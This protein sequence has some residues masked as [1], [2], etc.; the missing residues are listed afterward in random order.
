MGHAE[1]HEA[2]HPTFQAGS[3][4]AR[5]QFNSLT[6]AGKKFCHYVPLAP[7]DGYYRTVMVVEGE[8]GYFDLG[9]STKDLARAERDASAKNHRLGLSEDDATR[10][11][12]SSIKAQL[13]R[14]GR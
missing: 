7:Q 6:S 14:K 9:V 8:P 1:Q 10:I 12:C 5:N 2:Q 4:L 3:L 13:N 11:V